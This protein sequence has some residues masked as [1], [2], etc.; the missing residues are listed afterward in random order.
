MKQLMDIIIKKSVLKDLII[1]IFL[2]SIYLLACF[3]EIQGTTN[4][5][6]KIYQILYN[7]QML[8]NDMSTFCFQFKCHLSIYE[9]TVIL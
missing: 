9:L 4:L 1:L 6:Y 7:S 3:N 5:F 8:Q 2:Y